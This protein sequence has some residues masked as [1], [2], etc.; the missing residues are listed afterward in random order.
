[1]GGVLVRAKEGLSE[2]DV[3]VNAA[4]E[5]AE[6]RERKK[7]DQVDFLH[8]SANPTPPSSSRIATATSDGE[9]KEKRGEGVSSSTPSN[10]SREVQLDASPEKKESHPR[11]VT[12]ILP[13]SDV[14][15]GWPVDFF[16]E[17]DQ[18]HLP[19]M[20][21]VLRG[22]KDFC[23]WGDDG[24]VDKILDSMT[25]S[26]MLE[27]T[28][29]YDWD[30]VLQVVCRQLDITAQVYVLNDESIVTGC[31]ASNQTNKSRT[32]FRVVETER[33][34]LAVVAQRGQTH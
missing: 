20:G 15:A 23:L 11:L 27:T 2:G 28:T 19:S 6:N 8:D 18:S 31:T 10:T 9:D 16:L 21:S 4:I 34:C 1:M 22:V 24:A 33:P 26:Q 7:G 14:S 32:V 30:L 25:M 13:V 17:G 3:A 5:Q 12:F 29:S